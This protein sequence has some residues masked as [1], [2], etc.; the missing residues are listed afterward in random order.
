MLCFKNIST[1]GS[2]VWS[3]SYIIIYWILFLCSTT[4]VG[5]KNKLTLEDLKLLFSVWF[6]TDYD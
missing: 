4:G 6:C 5:S 1:E 2:I 3:F